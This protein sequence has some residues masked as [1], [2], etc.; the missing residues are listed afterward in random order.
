MKYIIGLGLIL[1]GLYFFP[2]ISSSTGG[3]CQALESKMVDELPLEQNSA[4]AL[5]A[6]VLTNISQGEAGKAYAADQYPKL[7]EPLGCAVG[8]YTFDKD[9]IGL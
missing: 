4:G 6:G 1:M 8:Y 5:L 2:Q 3:P 7:P 9:D